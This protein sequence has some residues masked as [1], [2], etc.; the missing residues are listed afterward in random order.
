MNREV[1]KQESL[2]A[3]GNSVC[4]ECKPHPRRLDWDGLPEARN[5]DSHARPS[6]SAFCR[7]PAWASSTAPL[8]SLLAA[9]EGS[10]RSLVVWEARR[11]RPVYLFLWLP[12]CWARGGNDYFRSRRPHPASSSQPSPRAPGLSR[13]FSDASSCAFPP[14]IRSIDGSCPLLLDQ[15]YFTPAV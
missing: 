1:G 15:E 11:K 10:S 9:A 13:A 4:G 3:N 14:A 5:G 2:R 8:A 7:P 12:P 6:R